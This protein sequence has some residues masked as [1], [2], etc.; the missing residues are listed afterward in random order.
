MVENWWNVQPQNCGVPKAQAGIVGF[1]S[2]SPPSARGE[3]RRDE[4]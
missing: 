2:P 4:A 1:D 3:R